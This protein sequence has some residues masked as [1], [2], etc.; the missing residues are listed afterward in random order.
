MP[1]KVP[2][3][4]TLS[5]GEQRLQKIQQARLATKTVAK[6]VAHKGV[7]ARP[8]DKNLSQILDRKR[9]EVQK[10][11]TSAA[12][13][14][15]QQPEESE[16]EWVNPESGA[17]EREAMADANSEKTGTQ[18]ATSVGRLQTA[19]GTAGL[20]QKRTPPPEPPDMAI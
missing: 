1:A 16:A 14:G 20:P 13:L 19:E 6:S 12:R 8:M 17:A 10:G 18:R 7:V 11:G 2:E 3:E 15:Q 5:R 9:A 4:P